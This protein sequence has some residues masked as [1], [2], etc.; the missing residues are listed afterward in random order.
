M[1][2]ILGS[3]KMNVIQRRNIFCFYCS[4]STQFRENIKQ[5]FS[6]PSVCWLLWLLGR[7]R[8]RLHSGWRVSKRSS[9]YYRPFF[10]GTHEKK[11]HFETRFAPVS[12]STKCIFL[13]PI[14]A[15]RHKLLDFFCRWLGLEKQK[16]I[17]RNNNY[18]EAT[19]CLAK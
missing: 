10:I 2:R 8:K 1:L 14:I 5:K 7:E 15:E 19:K 12:T 9:C 3:C 18:Y 4:T 6:M 11:L 16:K 13:F 17:I